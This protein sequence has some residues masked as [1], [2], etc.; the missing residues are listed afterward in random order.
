M[1]Y[2]GLS[3]ALGDKIGAFKSWFLS[4]TSPETITRCLRAL[5][6]NG[7]ITLSPEQAKQRQER[8]NEWRKYWGN[9]RR[10]SERM[11]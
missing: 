10:V 4:A 2:D 3:E 11:L 1:A 5:K 8:E 7:T 9:E 6:E